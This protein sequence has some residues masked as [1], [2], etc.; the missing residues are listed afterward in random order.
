MNGMSPTRCARSHA[1]RDRA[2]VI[3]HLVER[4]RQRVGAA[5]HDHAERVA[6][7]EDVDAG[8]ID[9]AGERRV[10]GGDTAVFSP[11]ALRARSV[12]VV[13]FAEAS[14]IESA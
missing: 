5:L 8:A 6:D 4:D 7:E 14:A 10:V 13:I 11:L 3:D 12:A 9:Q 2:R 1:A